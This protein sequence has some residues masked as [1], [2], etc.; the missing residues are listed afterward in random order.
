MN[1]YFYLIVL[2]ATFTFS[3]FSQSLRIEP[4]NWW[5]G[6]KNPKLQILIQGND[7]K[8]SE[9]L[10]SKAGLKITKVHFADSPNYLFLDCFVAPNAQ[11]GNYPLIIKKAGKVLHT[12]NYRLE[13]R[14]KGSANRSS[15][16]PQD[17]IYLITPD[18]FA[19]GDESNDAAP[20]MLEPQPKR[21]EMYGRHGG[22]IKG[23][24]DRL[25]YI[26][27]MGFTAIWN[28][29]LVENDQKRESYH[30]YSIT[31]HYQI[32][33][34]FGTNEQ[35]REFT[36]LAK[37]KGIKMISDV[38]L[39]HIGDGHYWM[40][41]LPFKNW[42]NFNGKFVS[43]THHREVQQDPHG[44]KADLKLQVEGWFVPTMPD[45]NQNNPFLAT[46]LIQNSIWWVEYADLGGIRIDTYP[47]SVKEFAN[48]WS[49]ALLNEYP[50]L[51]L[52]GEEWSSNPI[53]TSYWQKGKVNANGF[54][55]TLPSLMDFPLQ[56]VIAESLNENDKEWGKGLM[57]LYTALSNDLVYPDPYNLVV[58]GDNHD[59][60]RFFT[61]VKN[62][63][64]LFKM[65][66]AFIL[67]TRGIPQIYYGTEVLFSNP[68]SSEHGEIR[69]DFHGGWKGD[70]KDAVSGKN[71][72]PEEKD[73]QNF[74]RKLL[75]WRKTNSAIHQGKLLH[76]AP[77]NGVYTYFR[78]HSKSKVMVIMNKNASNTSIDLKRFE[79][80]LPKNAQVKDVL[81]DRTFTLSET[82]NVSGKTAVI[83]EIIQ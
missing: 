9:V 51:N 65:G 74:M 54:V 67:T 44:S 69:A 27:N 2:L 75:N 55:S 1:R 22:D 12:I 37:S 71:L 79:E 70:L 77:E 17:V 8:G 21:S 52:V 31:N 18:R 64:D 13:A 28:M 39:N 26:K 56:S 25:D 4:L 49:S 3:S 72:S 23:I 43:T 11:A 16:G 29:P 46:Y 61:Q 63:I 48:R 62:D 76:F 81:N 59:M 57:K 7:L 6:M 82:L 40:K 24:Q 19:N 53:I 80:I 83:L 50:K 73:A 45:L 68:K 42:L 35:F 60:S 32:D 78:H 14:E 5:V 36:K 30:G 41:D 34:R 47:Y 38:V 20:Q 58:F 66:M 33:P 10:S 15:F